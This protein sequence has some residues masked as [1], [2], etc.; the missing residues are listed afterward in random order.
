M[1]GQDK[2]GPQGLGPKTGRQMGNCENVV[3]NAGMGR[4]LGQCGGGRRMGCG[5]GLGRGFGCTRQV[6]LSKDEEK[7]ILEAERSEIDVRLKELA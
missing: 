5:R 1:P 2:T 4:G 3:P 6:T 7:K